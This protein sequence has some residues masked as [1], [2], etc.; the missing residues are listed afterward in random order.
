[1][2]QFHN[3]NDVIESIASSIDGIQ[4]FVFGH[5]DNGD[6]A[7]FHMEN[8]NFSKIWSV[9][10]PVECFSDGIVLDTAKVR[11]LIKKAVTA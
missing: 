10:I 9:K 4:R 3:L 7:V 2:L 8:Y 1:M 11:D 6:F 5:E